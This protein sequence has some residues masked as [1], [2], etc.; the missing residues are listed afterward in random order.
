MASLSVVEV[1]PVVKCG[2][3]LVVAGVDLVVGPFG[4]QGAVEAFDFAVLPGAVRFDQD[5]FS[6][7][8]G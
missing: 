1:Q 7:E 4:L 5:V 2:G 6:A 8:G 3:A